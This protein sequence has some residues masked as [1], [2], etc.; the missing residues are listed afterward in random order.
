MNSASSASASISRC[1]LRSLAPGSTKSDSVGSVS[2]SHASALASRG[3]PH[4]DALADVYCTAARFRLEDL[5]RQADADAEPD[6]AGVS[7]RWLSGD[8][9]DFLLSDVLIRR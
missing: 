1:A 4:A 3:Q 5:W 2:G 7:E 8:T 9:L 6:F